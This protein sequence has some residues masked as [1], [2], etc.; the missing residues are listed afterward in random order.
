MAHVTLLAD[1][2]VRLPAAGPLPTSDGELRRLVI[3]GRPVVGIVVE[4]GDLDNVR[5]DQDADEDHGA[6]ER[7]DDRVGPHS[8]DNVEPQV[9]KVP[10]REDCSR[11]WAS[12][13]V[14]FRRRTFDSPTLTESTVG[15]L[16]NVPSNSDFP[17][18][19]CS[20]PYRF[21]ISRSSRRE[22]GVETCRAPTSAA[23]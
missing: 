19:A 1:R 8:R 6:E 14:V 23:S 4:V 22:V 18:H 9:L 13:E 15:S 10:E 11:K 7:V 17:D 12:H 5:V 21:A 16:V 2:R 20:T 3:D